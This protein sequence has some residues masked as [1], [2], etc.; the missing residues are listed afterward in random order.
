MSKSK[1]LAVPEGYTREQLIKMSGTVVGGSDEFL[2]NLGINMNM[3]DEQGNDGLP[4]PSYRVKVKEHGWVYAGR[5]EVVTFRPYVHALR[6]EKWLNKE[7]TFQY[8]SIFKD[9]REE[10]IDELGG[11]DKLGGKENGARCKHLIY[12]TVS[13]DEGTTLE[14]AKVPIKDFP[15]LLRVGGGKYMDTNDTFKQFGDERWL[16]QFQLFLTPVKSGQAYNT[17]MDWVSLVDELPVSEEDWITFQNFL[18]EVRSFNAGI[19][20]KY[21]RAL[22]DVDVPDSESDEEFE[23]INNK[24]E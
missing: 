1:E 23:F 17:D 20:N 13:F 15:C 24:E 10:I 12:G 18:D 16:P 6:Y 3:E 11:V 5:K 22:A 14:G 8:T 7:K 21:K 9:F 19:T 4:T 2:P